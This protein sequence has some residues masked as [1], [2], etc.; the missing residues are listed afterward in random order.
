MTDNIHELS[1]SHKGLT[2]LT[3]SRE[4]ILNIT[5]LIIRTGSHD[6]ANVVL[7]YIILKYNILNIPR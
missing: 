4:V 1:G 3:N 5:Y 7:C 2:N 6:K